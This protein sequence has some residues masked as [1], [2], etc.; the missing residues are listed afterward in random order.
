MW[1]ISIFIRKVLNIGTSVIILLWSSF[2]FSYLLLKVHS[3]IMNISCWMIISVMN[4]HKKK[5][6][7]LCSFKKILWSNLWWQNKLYLSNKSISGVGITNDL[8][9]YPPSDSY[10]SQ[11]CFVPQIVE[12][13]V[14]LVCKIAHQSLYMYTKA[15]KLLHALRVL[16]PVAWRAT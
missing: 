1:S 12:Q 5:S 4:K 2:C 11:T 13:K 8:H 6:E 9:Q 7:D 15:P 3:F 10:L 16:S 14:S